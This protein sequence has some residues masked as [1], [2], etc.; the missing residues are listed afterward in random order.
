MGTSLIHTQDSLHYTSLHFVTRTRLHLWTFVSTVTNLRVRWNVGNST[1]F[2]P[3]RTWLISTIY[4]WYRVSQKSLDAG[5]MLIELLWHSKGKAIPFTGLARP[6]GFQEAEAPRFQDNRHMKVVRSGLRTGRLEPQEIFL[7]LISVRGWDDPSAIGRPEGLCQWK[8]PM[9]P[10]GIEPATFGL[11]AQRLWHITHICWPFEMFKVSSFNICK[12]T[13]YF[14]RNVATCGQLRQ[15]HYLCVDFVVKHRMSSDFSTILYMIEYCL[16]VIRRVCNPRSSKILW[17]VFGL[18]NVHSSVSEAGEM[19]S[20]RR[21]VSEASHSIDVTGWCNIHVEGW[22]PLVHLP[23]ARRRYVSA[24]P[25]LCPV[26]P[27]VSFYVSAG[28]HLFTN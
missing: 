10:S 24:P 5:E 11:V 21:R 6:W 7:V 12:L 15:K 3:R 14:L 18:S 25:L 16:N 19:H 8:I 26:V 4:E 9:A 17:N 22:K 28:F 20:R 13:E 1:V 2:F 23:C 27:G